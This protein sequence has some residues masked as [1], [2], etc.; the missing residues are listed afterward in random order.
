MNILLVTGTIPYPPDQGA[1]IRNLHLLQELSQHANVYLLSF[2]RGREDLHSVEVLKEYC[3]EV[4]TVPHGRGIFRRAVDL[5]RSIYSGIP[6]TVVAHLSK[7]LRRT[8]VEAVHSRRID[9]VQFQEVYVAGNIFKARPEVPCILDAHNCEAQILERT[10]RLERNAVKRIYYAHQRR[11]MSVYE[12]KIAGAFDA[13]FAVSGQDREFFANI[14]RHVALVPNGAPECE[15]VL[16]SRD[17]GILF[18]GTLQYPPNRDAVLFFLREIWPEISAGNPDVWIDIV[19]R[20]PGRALI[21]YAGPR[22]RFHTDCEDIQPFFRSSRLLVVPLR[23]GSGTRLKILQAFAAGLPVVSTS[24]GAEGISAQNNQHLLLRD[25]PRELAAAV[26]ELLR[27]P[28]RANALAR[29][30][31]TLIT[32]HYLWGDIVKE[33]WKTYQLFAA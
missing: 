8:L 5:G 29:E 2:I 33:C 27:S 24:L 21:R 10:T 14:S 19:G 12:K 6:Y 23:A 25:V 1:K 9:I 20:S 22:V 28:E 31:R 4:I 17:G 30:A 26:L 15:A 18:T 32:E 16:G 7:A 13:V 11:I 3:I